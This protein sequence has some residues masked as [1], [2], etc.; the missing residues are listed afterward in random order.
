MAR[1]L[2]SLLEQ[3]K[4]VF[5]TLLIGRCEVRLK[6]HIVIVVWGDA[7]LKLLLGVTIPN[8][9]ALVHEIPEDIRVVS[10]VRILTDGPGSRQLREAR[11]LSK[12]G[13]LMAVEIVDNLKIEEIDPADMAKFGGYAPMAL[14]QSRAVV[15]AS[16]EGAALIF[17]GPDLIFS[18]GAFALF[19]RK[20]SEGY[21][22]IVGPNLRIKAESAGEELRH[23]IESGTNEE[24]LLALSPSDLVRLSLKYFH[25][26]NQIMNIDSRRSFFVKADVLAEV[27][28]NQYL[29]KHLTGPVYFAYPFAGVTDYK[30]MINQHLVL[31]CCKRRS[32]IYVVTGSLE[33]FSVDLMCESFD[34][35][36]LL[37]CSTPWIALFRQLMDLEKIN[38]FNLWYALRTARIADSEWQGG[39]SALMA[40]VKFNI[41][42]GVL[43]VLAMLLRPARRIARAFRG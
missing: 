26:W 18:E 3:C 25:P 24:D 19:V 6:I 42:V 30:G 32:Q 23:R 5:G 11:R 38:R 43:L 9:C 2:R 15:E 41:A 22:F 17:V 20:A 36:S 34:V 29:M 13:A 28:P 35:D 12:L 37:N 39:L 4:Q 1:H 16:A 21:R 40:E 33:L 7:Y 14:A 10:R 8:L 27:S 31:H